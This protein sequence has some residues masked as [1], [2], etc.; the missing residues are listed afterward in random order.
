MKERLKNISI[1]IAA[2]VP[3]LAV[4]AS[5]QDATADEASLATLVKEALDRSAEIQVMGH[6]VAAKRARVP[7]AGALPDPLAMYGVINQRPP[8]PFPTLANKDFTS[9]SL[10]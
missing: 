3:L 4:P 10:A 8:A 1:A 7:Q 9:A 6:R 2:V 5:A